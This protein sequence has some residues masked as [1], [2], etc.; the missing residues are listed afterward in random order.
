MARVWRPVLRSV[1]GAVA[2]KYQNA[3]PGVGGWT[4]A[5]WFLASE[6]GAWYDPS[7]F[8]R[9]MAG[10][11]NLFPDPDWATLGGWEVVTNA[12]IAVSG[13]ELIVTATDINPTAGYRLTTVIG[14][15]YE[16]QITLADDAMTGNTFIGA[17]SGGGDGWAANLAN[18]NMGST[19]GRY[20]I[21]FTATTTDSRITVFGSAFAIAGE[22]FRVTRPVVRELTAI[23][24]ATMFQDSAGTI[25]VTAVEQPVGLALDKS[26]RG[27]HA[28]QPTAAAR[29]VLSARKNLL[30]RTESLGT[31][32]WSIENVTITTG[33]AANAVGQMTLCKVM[34]TATAAT[35]VSQS[36]GAVGSSAGNTVRFLARKGSGATG[37][38]SFGLYNASAGTLLI[39]F[40]VNYDTGVVTHSYGSGATMTDLGGGLWEVKYTCT[41]GIAAGN[42]LQIYGGF[43]GN[44][45]T[46]G[47]FAYI[48]E[49]QL[50]HGSTATTYQR[51]TTSTDYDTVGFPHYFSLD[52]VDDHVTAAAGGGGT[53]G[54]C[55]CAAIRAGGAGNARTIFSDRGTNTGYRLSI[56][57]SN[58]LVLS[59]GN[60][61]A[62]TEVVGPT[63]TAGTDYVVTGWHDGTNLNVQLNAW[64]ATSAAFGTATAG[65]AGFTIGKDNGAATGYY[66]ERI[67]EIVYRKNDTSTAGDRD[68][69]ITYMA[70]QAGITL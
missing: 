5:L 36:P 13:G 39:L 41:T 38:N 45:E 27:N 9:Y 21:V 32:P 50:E 22:T 34:A 24:T 30:E 58:Q 60:G 4:P 15:Q 18:V 54:I 2:R 40:T 12:T 52:R 16:V 65:T 20:S 53:T 63:V 26:G 61:S 56:N 57:A 62:H 25:P 46:A 33:Q 42:N 51:V 10:G 49:F 29:P 37:C 67:Y 3:D 44:T 66:G 43:T 23:N 17:G 7:D 35:I 8:A 47:E 28:S 6:Q 59:A 48:G 1:L 31:A 68:S 64:A 19:L 69:L 55:V 11:P 14:T 70:A